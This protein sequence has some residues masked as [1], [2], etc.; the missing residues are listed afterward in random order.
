MKDSLNTYLA[1]TLT[2]ENWRTRDT[3]GPV[4][5]LSLSSNIS[6]HTSVSKRVFGEKIYLGKLDAG[7]KRG[8]FYITYLGYSKG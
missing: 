6:F 1:Y 7:R 5:I 3:N 4:S 8:V 2:E